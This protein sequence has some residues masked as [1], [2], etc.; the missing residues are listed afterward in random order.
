MGMRREFRGTS[1][2][3]LC[4]AR[5][6]ASGW[7]TSCWKWRNGP[8]PASRSSCPCRARISPYYLGLTL[9]TVSR[10][11]TQLENESAIAL[12]TSKRIVLCN[13]A[14]SSGWSLEFPP[15]RRGQRFE[16]YQQGLGLNCA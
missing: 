1:D 4:S 11:L 2:R 5:P 12:A 10:M 9:E 16:P 7:P 6:R 3:V 15:T 13:R 14:C 8:A